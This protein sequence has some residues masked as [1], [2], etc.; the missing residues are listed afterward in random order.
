L[1]SLKLSL[2]DDSEIIMKVYYP[3]KKRNNIQRVA[4]H[5]SLCYSNNR[6]SFKASSKYTKRYCG[7]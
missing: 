3:Y 6:N 2:A 5:S 1:E 4:Y 7:L